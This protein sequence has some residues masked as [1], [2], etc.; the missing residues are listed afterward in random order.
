M[1]GLIASHFHATLVVALCV[2]ALVSAWLSH[3]RHDSTAVSLLHA[4]V[5]LVVA[6]T[7][8]YHPAL[9]VALIGFLFPVAAQ[10]SLATYA[11]A[12]LGKDGF[13]AFLRNLVRRGGIVVPVVSGL[14][15]ATFLGSLAGLLLLLSRSTEWGYWIAIGMLVFATVSGVSWVFTFG[16]V[17]WNVTHAADAQVV[18]RE[19]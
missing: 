9:T 17:W 1:R 5:F 13:D 8:L 6:P 16:R 2:A 15:W 12:A 18:S 7:V 19:A 10:N 3:L 11:K 4:F 14:A